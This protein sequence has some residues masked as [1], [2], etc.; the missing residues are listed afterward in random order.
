MT[1][2]P[3]MFPRAFAEI[4]LLLQTIR[5]AELKSRNSGPCMAH[6]LLWHVVKSV[7][8]GTYQVAQQMG[9]IGRE[10]CNRYQ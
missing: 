8:G 10:S 7:P 6:P 4:T 9:N 1:E 5:E 3:T 2:V